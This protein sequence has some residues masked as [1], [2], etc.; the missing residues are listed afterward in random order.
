MNT[1]KN[2]INS[3]HPLDIKVLCGHVLIGQQNIYIFDWSFMTF[4]KAN[5]NIVF[6]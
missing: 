5:F 3:F 1:K 4:P 6:F 2:I